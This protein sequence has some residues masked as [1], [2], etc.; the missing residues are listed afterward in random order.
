MSTQHQPDE[1]EKLLQFLYLAPAALLELKPDGTIVLM[2]AQASQH[3][4]PLSPGG[5]TNFFEVMR[6]FAPEVVQ[7][8]EAFSAE[9]GSIISN[10]RVAVQPRGDEAGWVYFSL[11]VEKLG[12]GSLM[13][14]LVDV[15]RVVEQDQRVKLAIEQ[16]AVQRGKAELAASV[17][18]DI[19]NAVTGLGTIVAQLLGNEAWREEHA[20]VRLEEYLR[21]H[22][23]GLNE[24]L[25]A[26]KGEAL[27]Q[28]L[29]EIRTALQERASDLDESHARMAQIVTHISEILSLQ[30]RYAEETQAQA[31]STHCE[32][33]QLVE[34]AIS[35]QAAGLE[36]RSI[37]LKRDYPKHSIPITADRTKLVR[38]FVNLFRNACES[39]DR[40]S[41]RNDENRIGV[42]VTTLT[43]G[44]VEVTIR[45]N[46]SGFEPSEA[47]QIL[48][49]NVSSKRSGGGLG[50]PAC[51]QIVESHGGSLNLESAGESRGA[52][53]TVRIPATTSASANGEHGHNRVH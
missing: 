4:M 14:A 37:A 12:P 35:M 20:I 11:T 33:V 53:A 23:T 28:Y 10:R 26:G 3:L 43:S 31:E 27:L 18:H 36:K 16:E 17:L 1:T 48:E 45:D 22:L 42:A 41:I 5:L 50:L 24:A 13:A 29:A 44:M 39:F 40:R 51:K 25:G 19:G 15:T 34:D 32:I 46:G 8:I 7:A 9:S 49:R 6:P 38:V 21:G 47:A 2:N 52:T 30:R